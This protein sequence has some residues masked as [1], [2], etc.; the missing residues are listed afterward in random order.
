[1]KIASKD[2]T[3]MTTRIGH[4]SQFADPIVRLLKFAQ[5]TFSAASVTTAGMHLQRIV[6]MT[7]DV[8]WSSTVRATER[9]LDG[10]S[11]RQVGPL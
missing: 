1:M 8:A 6:E 3:V 7:Q 4:T 9:S 10:T 11:H 5:R 2:F